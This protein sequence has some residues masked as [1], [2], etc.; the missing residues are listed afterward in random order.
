M[1]STPASLSACLDVE[2]QWTYHIIV[3]IRR[4]I[5]YQEIVS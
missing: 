1:A 2:E 4:D 3:H 5:C